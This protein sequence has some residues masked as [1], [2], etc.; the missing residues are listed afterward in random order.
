MDMNTI[1]AKQDKQEMIR[2]VALKQQKAAV[3]LA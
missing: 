1:P 2:K 3:L